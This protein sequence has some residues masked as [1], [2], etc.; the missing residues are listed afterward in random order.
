[1]TK[2][3]K[4]IIFTIVFL[5]LVFN[6]F[7][8]FSQSIRLDEAQSIWVATKSLPMILKINAS[9]VQVPLYTLLLHFWI[10][11]FGTSITTVRLLSV[12]F[13]LLTL[14][15][16]Y[17]MIFESSNPKI[18]LLGT[19]IFS[20]S[21][22]ILW[23][24]NEARTYSLLTLAVCLNHLYFLRMKRTDA[25][26]SKTGYF[27]SSLLGLFSHYFFFFLLFTQVIF[28]LYQRSSPLFFRRFF[29]L[30]ALLALLLLPWGIYVLS[31]GLAT[32]TQPLLSPP[33]TF[34]LI[35]VFINFIFGF[36]NQSFGAFMVSLWPLILIIL[37]FIF[38]GKRTSELKNSTYFILTVFLP[39]ASVFL[40]SLYKPIFLARY[41]I[42]TTPSLFVLMAWIL[43]D[44]GKKVLSFLSLS[45]LLLMF[46]LLNYQNRSA[47]TP[48]REDYREI[49]NYLE[50][51]A[52]PS[53]IIVAS[54][55]FTIYPIEYSYNG[56]TKIDTLPLW[57][58]YAAGRIPKFS[59]NSLQ[60]QINAYKKIYY[61][62]FLVLSYDQG[63]Q[64]TI[65]DYLDH[66]YKLLKTTVYPADIQL[67]IYQLR[68]DPLV[69]F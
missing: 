44:Y 61:R 32:N 23:Y 15:V 50:K 53:D 41:L 69:K 64:N 31:Q 39:I 67:R 9:D 46:L 43:I 18:A 29:Y 1:M 5:S 37:F 3:E 20:L 16:L 17:Q 25:Q 55:P 30:L 63:Y 52:S 11:L 12:I 66:N 14:P 59:N 57:D 6:L 65:Q 34:S 54:A 58:R 4:L 60:E 56:I 62:L 19:T 26:T 48:V 35:S 45:I 10:Q 28:V 22:F 21:P 36:Q 2:L 24:S 47:S 27:L 13:F 42:L 7:S 49:A 8:L 40:I 33:T 38:T 51:N 68:Y